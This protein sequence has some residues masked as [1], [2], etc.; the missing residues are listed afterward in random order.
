M[1]PGSSARVIDF[2]AAVGRVR[3][4]RF[5]ERRRSLP[6][7]SLDRLLLA[8][9]ARP[10]DPKLLREIGCLF[11]ERASGT[12]P[13]SQDHPASADIARARCAFE[14]ALR[15]MRGNDR[16][17]SRFR[18]LVCLDLGILHSIQGEA[19]RAVTFLDAAARGLKGDTDTERLVGINL[20][21]VKAQ[22]GSLRDAA[23]EAIAAGGA[24][25]DSPF[26]TVARLYLAA[27][28]LDLDDPKSARRIA[29]SALSTIPVTDPNLGRVLFIFAVA[30]AGCG[31]LPEAEIAAEALIMRPTADLGIRTEG[32]FLLIEILARQNR[33]SE[34][35]S[36]IEKLEA[37][38]LSDRERV[39]VTA[40]K[41][42][43]LGGEARATAVTD[44]LTQ[45][46]KGGKTRDEVLLAS[47]SAV[48]LSDLEAQSDIN[49]DPSPEVIAALESASFTLRR[50][51]G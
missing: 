17:A 41:G 5:E 48:A 21:K 26:Y 33:K 22:V 20:A 9:R 23:R 35:I 30:A 16:E 42:C 31:H 27:W 13:E 10:H 4:R 6:V 46:K 14:H 39:R 24:S 38:S 2:S 12:G 25:P 28:Y 40:L 29:E 44:L 3:E 34:A 45:A 19:T 32:Y 18:A 11:Q 1:K 37:M 49:A 51:I 8:L 7:G 43:L 47:A 15:V 36:Q 50:F